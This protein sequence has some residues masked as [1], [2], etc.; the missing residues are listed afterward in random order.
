MTDSI[1]GSGRSLRILHVLRAPLGGLF[2]HVVDL[3]RGQIERGH[4]VGLLTDSTTGGASADRLLAELEP[5]LALGLLRLPMRRNPHPSDLSVL[6][7]IRGRADGLRPDVLHGH[8]SK[9][10][11]YVRWAGS[12]SG[13]DRAVRAYTPHGGS[14]NHRPGTLTSRLY[15]AAERLMAQRTDLLLFESHFIAD[16]FRAMVCEPPRLSKVVHNGVAEGEFVPLSPASDAADIL[17]VGELRAAKGIDTLLEA[18]AAVGKRLGSPPRALLV[19]SGPDRA[20][21]EEH[22]RKLGLGQRV[23]FAGPM[24]ARKAFELGRVLVVPSRAESLPYI[25]L[26][27]AAARIPLISTQVGGIPEIFGPYRS[28]LLPPDDVPLLAQRIIDTL[29]STPSERARQAGE[30]STFV[31]NGFSTDV[32][33]EAILGAY[34]DA[35]L[36]RAPSRLPTSA[37]VALSS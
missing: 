33:V 10:G 9:G 37:Q 23:A 17:Y 7:R 19:G 28:R 26:E 14:L 21:L 11:A 24:P 22:A 8:G 32:M 2:R 4:A 15:M 13:A 29:T 27:A 20:R 6:M 18:L 16:R 35:L 5:D 34:R 25:I 1:G 36:R 31:H 3:A 12:A 30:L